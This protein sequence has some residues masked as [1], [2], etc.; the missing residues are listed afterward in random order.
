MQKFEY[1][2]PEF[3]F[4][5]IPIKNGSQNDNRIW[6][7]HRL[8]LSL[9]E[10]IHVDRLKDFEFKGKQDRFEYLDQNWFGVFV[11]NNCEV[12]G[13]NQD[14]VLKKSWEFLKAHLIWLDAKNNN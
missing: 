10:F 5:Q 13:A 4:C 14:F 9:I 12:T 11:Q 6:V 2:Q 1:V 3:L 7:Y 8:S